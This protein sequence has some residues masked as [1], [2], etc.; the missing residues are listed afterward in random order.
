M[1][2]LVEGIR[3]YGINGAAAV[4]SVRLIFEGFL[5]LLF[6][7]RTLVPGSLKLPSVLIV[8]G[9]VLSAVSIF[10]PTGWP[11]IVW[12]TLV[13]IAGALISWRVLL[14]DQ[15]RKQVLSL[16]PQGAIGK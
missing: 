4:W 15:E 1:I 8:S 10:L 11:K 3:I 14:R 13:L 9:F 6:A 5:L 16:L 2:A 7:H 12:C